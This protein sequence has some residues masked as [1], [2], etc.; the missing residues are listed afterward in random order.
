[1]QSAKERFAL[2]RYQYIYGAILFLVASAVSP[3]CSALSPDMSLQPLSLLKVRRSAFIFL[4]PR[5]HLRIVSK[6]LA[7]LIA[8]PVALKL[9]L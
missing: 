5:R 8:S 9:Y 1:M 2:L 3:Q 6:M 4:S 7:E